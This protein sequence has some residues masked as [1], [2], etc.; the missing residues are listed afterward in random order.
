MLSYSKQ[1]YYC[2]SSRK[3][4]HFLDSEQPLEHT[5]RLGKKASNSLDYELV[6]LHNRSMNE[7]FHQ[8]KKFPILILSPN[9]QH[10]AYPA[11]SQIFGQTTIW[12]YPKVLQECRFLELGASPLLER[13]KHKCRFFGM[14]TFHIL[15]HTYSKERDTILIWLNPVCKPPQTLRPLQH[16]PRVYLKASYTMCLL[17]NS[18]TL[19]NSSECGRGE[20]EDSK[21]MP[22]PANSSQ[23]KKYRSSCL[24]RCWSRVAY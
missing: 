11:N 4:A 2:L 22:V 20:R 18:Q 14:K 3:V 8:M 21:W 7:K 10:M 15:I 12:N 13:R 9:K 24:W 19:K 6:H 1:H 17:A 23:S 16:T 5:P